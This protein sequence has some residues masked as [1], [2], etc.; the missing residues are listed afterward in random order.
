MMETAPTETIL[1]RDTHGHTCMLTVRYRVDPLT[2]NAHLVLFY[3]SKTVRLVDHE[4]DTFKMINRMNPRL[5]PPYS[6]IYYFLSKSA[7][8]T[9]EWGS[10]FY[11]GSRKC[12]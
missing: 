12:F 1:K 8:K 3:K 9:V 10:F 6:E 5:Q 7:L 2:F 11:F 4:N